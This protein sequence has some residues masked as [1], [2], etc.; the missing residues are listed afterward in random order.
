LN[1]LIKVI[2][3]DG[4]M[5]YRS[6]KFNENFHSIDGA[7]YETTSKFINPSRL[8][9]FENKSINVLDI[10]FGIGYNSALLFENLILE[11]S[12]LNWYG[13]ELDKR[14]LDYALNDKKF[15][16]LW[17]P[18]VLE[19]LNSLNLKGSYKNKNFDCDLIIGDA[20]KEILKI[21]KEVNFDLIY[22]DGFSPQKCPEIWTFEFL[23]QLQNKIKYEGYLIT[24]TSSAAVRKSLKNLGFNIFN[25]VPT[26]SKKNRWSNGTLATFDKR[27]NNPFISILSEREIE[28]LNT[29]ASIPYRDP[30][31]E[32]SSE[33]ILEIRKK[34]QHF[35]NLLDTN[36]WRK[37][38][39]MA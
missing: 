22:L 12:T 30:T 16:N 25:I 9:R 14:P 7:Y 37:K 10:C 26:L 38:W 15:N 2:T 8:K 1:N 6:E 21:P 13:L 33:E 20:R 27:Q 11:L 18:K 32:M 35:S 23:S 4:S 19:I 34:E 39:A 28:H 29:K 31:G 36:S 17:D 5:S 24:Y 3:K